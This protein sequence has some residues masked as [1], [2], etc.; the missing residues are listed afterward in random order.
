M[1]SIAGEHEDP[2][3]F[4]QTTLD[5]L[6]D[7]VFANHLL[8]LEKSPGDEIDAAI[9]DV[10]LALAQASFDDPELEAA[11]RNS[12]KKAVAERSAEALEDAALSF[13]AA[14]ELL[15]DQK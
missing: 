11:V 13:R 12:V 5:E 1:L 3:A 10:Q 6:D 8:C 2:E 15:I 4:V 14:R 9:A 7:A